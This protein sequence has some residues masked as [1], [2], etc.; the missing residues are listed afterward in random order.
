[1]YA[2]FDDSS[3]QIVDELER[4]LKSDDVI[5]FGSCIEHAPSDAGEVP[6]ST[7]EPHASPA[8]IGSSSNSF[9]STTSDAVFPSRLSES[10]VSQL[11]R[12]ESQLPRDSIE[13]PPK[14]LALCVNTGSI[15]KTLVEFEVSSKF[16][17][18][19][20]FRLMK[21]A[22]VNL[23]GIRALHSLLI[24]PVDVHFVHVS[25]N[26]FLGQCTKNSSVSA[27]ASSRRICFHP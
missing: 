11:G 25:F 1:M 22:Y 10:G 17:D 6:H 9:T 18:A 3:P 12:S 24:K 14:Y 4:L 20:V 21:E 16:S 13:N 19:D 26:S 15:Y 23:R 2:D 8:D 7:N 5:E 27:V